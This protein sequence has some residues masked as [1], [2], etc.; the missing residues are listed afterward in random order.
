MALRMNSI[1]KG[2]IPALNSRTEIAITRNE[3]RA[4]A[5]QAIAFIGSW[6]RGMVKSGVRGGA[7]RDAAPRK[8]A[9][10]SSPRQ[11]IIG[12]SPERRRRQVRPRTG[13]DRGRV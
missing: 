6:A 2:C 5:I 10:H 12:G 9:Q 11:K 4:A 1:W 8:V 7:K 3:A 13:L